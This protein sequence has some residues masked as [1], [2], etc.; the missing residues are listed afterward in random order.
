MEYKLLFGSCL[1]VTD[2]QIRQKINLLLQQARLFETTCVKCRDVDLTPRQRFHVPYESGSKSYDTIRPTIWPS[3]EIQTSPKLSISD[4]T[5]CCGARRRCRTWFRLGVYLGGS[6]TLML[7]WR[8][9]WQS[10]RTKARIAKLL[11]DFDE[12]PRK[13]HKV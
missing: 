4:L 1:N 3:G 12:E 11:G 5:A 2:Q 8:V 6:A 13:Q 10:L 7:P 9:L